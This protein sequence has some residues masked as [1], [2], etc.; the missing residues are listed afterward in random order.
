MVRLTHWDDVEVPASSEVMQWA[1]IDS[2]GRVRRVAADPPTWRSGGGCVNN[3]GASGGGL[4]LQSQRSS[5]HIVSR[6][7]VAM[8]QD[9]MAVVWDWP[10][11]ETEAAVDGDCCPG[12]VQ[13]ASEVVA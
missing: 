1:Y 4:K 8:D 2:A 3:A 9:K 12:Q 10:V 5:L 6:A 13:A 11:P 7:G